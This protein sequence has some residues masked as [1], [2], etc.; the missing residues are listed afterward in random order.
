[1]RVRIAPVLILFTFAIPAAAQMASFGTRSRAVIAPA[2]PVR[3]E[4][5]LPVGGF[6]ESGM[7]ADIPAPVAGSG[8]RLV[9]HSSFQSVNT[10]FLKQ[11]NVPMFSL[12]GGQFQVGC[13]FQRFPTRNLLWGLNQSQNVSSSD[14]Y[15]QPRAGVPMPQAE[16]SCGF[17]LSFSFHRGPD[18]ALRGHLHPV[19]CL[20]WF[21]GGRGGCMD[22]SDLRAVRN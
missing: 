10:P 4:K 1:M 19:S 8:L 9:L 18:S 7:R 6:V 22:G 14:L 16:K 13:F 15:R 21:F 17:R 20:A 2:A 12:S 3:T 5:V 11:V